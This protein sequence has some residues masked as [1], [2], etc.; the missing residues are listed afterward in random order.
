MTHDPF[1]SVLKVNFRKT[2]FI[3]FCFLMY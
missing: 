3:I 1:S 2:A